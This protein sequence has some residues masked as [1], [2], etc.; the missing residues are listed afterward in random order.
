MAS[1]AA[2]RAAHAPYA[3]ASDG[4]LSYPDAFSADFL[5]RG[6]FRR[7]RDAAAKPFEPRG[8]SRSRPAARHRRTC[9]PPGGRRR[10]ALAGRA[11]EPRADLR[12]HARYLVH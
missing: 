3:R 7:W 10:A 8:T 2:P 4:E 12:L 11:T 5:E 6:I 1:G 9:A